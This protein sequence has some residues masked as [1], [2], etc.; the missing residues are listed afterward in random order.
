MF[1]IYFGL[2]L[3]SRHDSSIPVETRKKSRT[4]F[5]KIDIKHLETASE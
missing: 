3:Y 2:L 5:A 1:G 4:F